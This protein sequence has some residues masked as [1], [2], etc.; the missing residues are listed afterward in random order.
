VQQDKATELWPDRLA[1]LN[2]LFQTDQYK[3]GV[4][5]LFFGGIDDFIEVAVCKCCVNNVNKLKSL[6]PH[7]RKTHLLVPL[8]L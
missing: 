6:L 7:L 8:K 5:V 1:I 3:L 4:R 2:Q